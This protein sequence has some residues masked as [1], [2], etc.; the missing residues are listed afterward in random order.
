MKPP[1]RRRNLPAH[2]SKRLVEIADQIKQ[3]KLHI[4]NGRPYYLA[5]GKVWG[6]IKTD[7]IVDELGLE[8]LQPL[9]ASIQWLNRC[10]VAWDGHESGDLGRGERYAEQIGYHPRYA[11]EPYLMAELTELWRTK[12][13]PRRRRT[14]PLAMITGKVFVRSEIVRFPHGTAVLGNCH[15]LIE[16]IPDGIIDAVI[17]DPPFGIWGGSSHGH[18]GKIQHSWDKPLDWDNLWPELWRV[19]NLTGS[20][21][22][23][24]AQ[25]LASTLIAAQLANFL[26][27][28]HYFRK[29]TN[30]YGPKYGRPMTMIEPIPVFSRA[31]HRE[32]TLNPQMRDLREVID[33]LRDPSRR[34]LFEPILAELEASS[35]HMS[36]RSLQ[37][38]DLILAQRT[39]YDSPRIQHGQKPVALMRYLIRAHT[40]PG[41]VVLDITAGSQT[42]A[43]AAALED[44]RFITFEQDRRHFALGTQRLHRL[45]AAKKLP[46]A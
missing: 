7:P 25:P 22:V 26:Y 13:P 29:A 46:A 40:R 6:P 16:E 18:L 15:H 14:F 44:R 9:P 32:R 1:S 31:G 35:R 34:R 37:P 38:I 3:A 24:A 5:I 28:W 2:I 45:Y 11:E 8:A 27:C 23:S 36:Y 30:M 43:V 12:K 17:N 33:R 42:T 21:V 20:I 39:I 19:T 4:R 10:L 41:D